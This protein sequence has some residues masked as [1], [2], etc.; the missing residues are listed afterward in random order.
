[1]QPAPRLSAD[2]WVA[3]YRARLGAAAIPVYLRARGTEA[4]AVLIKLAPLDGTARLYGQAFALEGPRAWE[5]R[6]HGPEPEIEARL[7]REMSRDPDLW[8]LEVEDAQGRVMLD[9]DMAF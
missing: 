4:G 7:A 5:E 6:A 2:L 9:A 8:V 1:M 3:A